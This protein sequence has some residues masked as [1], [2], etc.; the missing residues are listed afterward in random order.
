M[1]NFNL[2][3]NAIRYFHVRVSRLLHQDDAINVIVYYDRS[4]FGYLKRVLRVLMIYISVYF[5]VLEVAIGEYG[6][7][8]DKLVAAAETIPV[9]QKSIAPTT[10]LSD[11]SKAAFFFLISAVN[12]KVHIRAVYLIEIRIYH[13]SGEV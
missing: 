8:L 7:S 3:M 2:I 4:D 13:I 10:M 12:L 9:E 11:E 1:C 6:I 5:S